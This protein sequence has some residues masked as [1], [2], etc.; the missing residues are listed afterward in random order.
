MSLEFAG[1]VAL[2]TGGSRGIGRVAALRLARDGA[3][4]AI[5]Y[6]SRASQGDEVAAA[7]RLLGRRGLSLPCN[8]SRQDD[9]Q[10]LVAETRR[11]LGPIDLLVHSGGISNLK[12]HAELSYDVW[13]E[14]IDVNLTGTYLVVFAVKDDM[15]ERRFGRIVT[16]SSVAALLPRQFQIH[17]ATAKAGVIAFTR[18]CAEAF[19]PYNVRINGVAPGLIDTDMARVLNPEATQKVIEGT[20]MGRLGRPEEIAS[21]I[22]F[23]LSDESSFMT[24]QTIA[25]SGGRAMLP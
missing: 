22:R 2:V 13:R 20:P 12:T 18:C 3:D 5:S 21:V 25:V 19:A 24:G 7:I 23:L 14:M 16:L 6:A 11:Q 10:R 8:V 4:V 15:L 17:Y 9:V 1:R